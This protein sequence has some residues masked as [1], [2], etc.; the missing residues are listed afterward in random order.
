MKN[1]DINKHYTIQYALKGHE[2]TMNRGK[3]WIHFD[4]WWKILEE[5][6]SDWV[7]KDWLVFAKRA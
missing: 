1:R 6:K 4:K 5:V 3:K 7:L 2:N